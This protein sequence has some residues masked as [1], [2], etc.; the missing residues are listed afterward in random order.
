MGKRGR[1]RFAVAAHFTHF[2]RDGPRWRF[3]VEDILVDA[4]RACVVYRFALEGANAVWRERAG[5]AVVTFDASGAISEWRE[6]EG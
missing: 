2:F 5:C 6:Y 1:P 4:Q 3:D